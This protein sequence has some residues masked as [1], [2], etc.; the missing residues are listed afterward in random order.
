MTTQTTPQRQGKC[1]VHSSFDSIITEIGTDTIFHGSCVVNQPV[2]STCDMAA[3]R[4]VGR[5][6]RTY[7]GR[8]KIIVGYGDRAEL[9]YAAPRKRNFHTIC[10]KDATT[11]TGQTSYMTTALISKVSA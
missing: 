8:F 3:L 4:L 9:Q 6:D 2:F 7:S 10:I 1:T 11:W 5:K